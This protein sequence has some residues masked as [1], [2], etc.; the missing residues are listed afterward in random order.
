MCQ[1]P[2]YSI[3]IDPKIQQWVIWPGDVFYCRMA[4]R[5][6]E[7]DLNL[8]KGVKGTL[9]LYIIDPDNFQGGR[10]ETIVVGGDTVGTFENFQHGRWID[11]PVSAEKTADGKLSIRVI[12]A[13]KGSNAVLSDILWIEE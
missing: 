4:P 5:Q 3:S 1:Q 10:K 12:N 6:F 11:V 8:P 7:A 13:R 2:G 9:R